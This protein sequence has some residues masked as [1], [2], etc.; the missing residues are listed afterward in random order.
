MKGLC[1]FQKMWLPTRIFDVDSQSHTTNLN[2]LDEGFS[3][4]EELSKSEKI[5][6]L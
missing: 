4:T 6:I 2:K 1:K 5:V 3:S